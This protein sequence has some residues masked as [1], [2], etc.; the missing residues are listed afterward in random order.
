MKVVNRGAGRKTVRRR[1]ESQCGLS[2]FG[3]E[4]LI[5]QQHPIAAKKL[6]TRGAAPLTMRAA[7]FEQV[8]KVAFE[9]NRKPQVDGVI[10]VIADAKTLIG[11]TAPKKNRAQNMNPVLFQDDVLTIHQIRIGQVDEERGIVVTER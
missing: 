1:I 4:P 3:V 2:H 10:A 8:G 6:G 11:C 5:D 9:Q 7:D